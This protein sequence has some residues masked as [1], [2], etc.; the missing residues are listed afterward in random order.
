MT[1]DV[2]E[3]VTEWHEF[4]ASKHTLGRLATNVAVL[5]MGKHRTDYAAHKVAPVN[6]I[7]TNTDR[8]KVTGNKKQDKKYRWYTGYPGGLKERSMEVQLNKD[9][10]E[11]IRLA[12]SGMLPKNKLRVKMLGQLRLYKGATHPHTTHVEGAVKKPKQK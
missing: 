2:K 3:N 8:V 5:L 11:V 1:K 6:V 12:V 9:S 10:R 7:I 4:D